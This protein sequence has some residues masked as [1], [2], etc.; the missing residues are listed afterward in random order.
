MFHVAPWV[1]TEPQHDSFQV[2]K[3]NQR[4][5]IMQ[6]YLLKEH[7]RYDENV[8]LSGMKIHLDLLNLTKTRVLG[9]I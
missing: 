7:E 3:Q 9:P 1:I 4:Q 8:N 6:P 5:G 2:L